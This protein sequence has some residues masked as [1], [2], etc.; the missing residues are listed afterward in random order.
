MEDPNRNMLINKSLLK[1][2]YSSFKLEILEYC[3]VNLL[4]E[5]EQYFIDLFQPEPPLP[6]P[7]GEGGSVAL[8][9]EQPPV[10]G[11]GREVPPP[12]PT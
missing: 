9:V 10:R 12:L 5:R 3:D 7:L 6:Y 2:D 11:G 1:N 4:I 8:F